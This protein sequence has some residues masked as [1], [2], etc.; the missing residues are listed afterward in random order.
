MKRQ[1]NKKKY[2]VKS[3]H[4]IMYKRLESLQ[5]RMRLSEGGAQECR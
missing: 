4:H 3:Y 5:N 1:L 2:I